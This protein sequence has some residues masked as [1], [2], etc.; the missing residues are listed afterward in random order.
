MRGIVRPVLF[1]A[2]AVVMVTLAALGRLRETT[3]P[4]V[5]GR[6]PR[7]PHRRTAARVL[8]LQADVADLHDRN[9]SLAGQ[10]RRLRERADTPRT[11]P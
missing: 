7:C 6:C 5:D 8:D 3:R 10:N 4:P 1:A 11:A 2:G 9:A